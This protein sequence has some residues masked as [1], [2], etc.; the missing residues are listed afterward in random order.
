MRRAPER[1]QLK[2]R[3][4]V[5]FTHRNATVGRRK[6]AGDDQRVVMVERVGVRA[7]L[8]LGLRQP[9]TFGHAGFEPVQ[10]GRF[11]KLHRAHPL[12]SLSRVRE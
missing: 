7:P 1:D 10:P 9:E 12:S 6:N 5:T 2:R 8:H 3:Q 4:A 11:P